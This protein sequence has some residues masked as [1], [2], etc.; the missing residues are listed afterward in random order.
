M[1]GESVSEKAGELFPVIFQYLPVF[2]Y[3][4]LFDET[5]YVIFASFYKAFWKPCHEI[6]EKG[7]DVLRPVYDDFHGMEAHP[8]RRPLDELIAKDFVFRSAMS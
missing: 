3:G 6:P 4:E 8:S 5:L 7:Q 1:P 2:V